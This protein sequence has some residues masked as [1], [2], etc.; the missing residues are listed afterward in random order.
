MV[1]LT[2]SNETFNFRINYEKPIGSKC[3]SDVDCS[4]R[5]SITDLIQCDRLSETCQCSDENITTV[6][7][8]GIG[9]LCSD[10]I[11]RSN[12]TKHPQR[13]LQWCNESETSYCICPKWTRKVRK[14]NGIFDCELEPRGICRFEDEEEIGVNIRKC[15]TGK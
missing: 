1:Y 10:S 15:P 5:Y 3:Q 7:L 8:P 9:R 6:D 14:I 11:D 12:C 2:A 13:C 4:T